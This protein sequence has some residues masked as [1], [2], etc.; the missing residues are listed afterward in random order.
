[1]PIET[2]ASLAA[3]F[4]ISSRFLDLIFL[5]CSVALVKVKDEASFVI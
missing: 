4:F 5:K 3:K 2:V 1:M